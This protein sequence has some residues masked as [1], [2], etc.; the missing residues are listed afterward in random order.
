MTRRRLLLLGVVV[1]LAASAGIAYATIPDAGGVI[2]ACYKSTGDNAGAVRVI[3]APAQSCKAS[4][5]ALDWNQT[6]PQGPQGPSG[7]QG[8]QGPSGPQGPA[9][10]A[11]G[12][13]R[14]SQVGGPIIGTQDVLTLQVSARRSMLFATV[15]LGNENEVAARPGICDLISPNGPAARGFVDIQPNSRAQLSLITVGDLPGTAKV[16]CYDPGDGSIFL[17]APTTLAVVELSTLD[18]Q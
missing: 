6:G 9:G 16:T 11:A 7:P 1:A 13:F 8:P 10:G 18:Q 5:S 4:E 17:D 14:Q 15:Q 3:D 12:L 2:H